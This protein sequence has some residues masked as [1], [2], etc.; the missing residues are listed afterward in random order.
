MTLMLNQCYHMNLT[1]D[2]LCVPEL[3]VFRDRR[4]KNEIETCVF[5]ALY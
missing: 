5:S 1:A 2:N 3:L 4:F